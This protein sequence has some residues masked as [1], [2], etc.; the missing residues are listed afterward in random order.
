MG[1]ATLKSI[2]ERIVDQIIKVHKTEQR[3]SQ[4]KGEENTPPRKAKAA[5]TVLTSRW[6][7][8]NAPFLNNKWVNVSRISEKIRKTSIFKVNLFLII[9]ATPDIGVKIIRL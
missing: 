5:E 8:V 3:P 7:W 2:F 4:R 1:T 6:S 9:A